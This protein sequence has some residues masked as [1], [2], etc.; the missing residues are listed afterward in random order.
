MGHIRSKPGR[1][2]LLALPTGD[3]VP[4]ERASPKE[5]APT[6][7][8]SAK[9]ALLGLQHATTQ[10][11]QFGELDD[12]ILMSLTQNSRR[13]HVTTYWLLKITDDHLAKFVALARC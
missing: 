11:L 8:P 10:I 2:S 1:A 6:G 13:I 3:D 5:D 4:T 7:S 12:Q 9:H